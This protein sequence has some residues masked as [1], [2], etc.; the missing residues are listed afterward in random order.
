MATDNPLRAAD[1][2]KEKHPADAQAGGA[3]MKGNGKASGWR[4]KNFP[5]A[6]R[7]KGKGKT[8][9]AGVGQKGKGKAAK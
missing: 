9:G 3:A 1:D 8:K 4:K 7:G 6:R 2:P 5:I